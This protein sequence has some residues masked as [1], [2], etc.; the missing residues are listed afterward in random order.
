LTKEEER[1][2]RACMV[3][4]TGAIMPE[5][6]SHHFVDALTAL[7]HAMAVALAG[8]MFIKTDSEEERKQILEESITRLAEHLRKECPTH[9]LGMEATRVP[10]RTDH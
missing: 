2:A 7:T 10:G 3:R 9:V 5:L 8:A 4:V 1:I 6:L